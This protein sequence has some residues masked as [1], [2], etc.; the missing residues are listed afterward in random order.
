MNELLFFSFA[1]FLLALNLAAFSC[2]PWG[3]VIPADLFWPV[4]AATYAVKVLMALLDTP[5]M[6]LSYR[7]KRA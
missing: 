4:C 7:I 6:Y 5:F 2:L 3:G 1:A